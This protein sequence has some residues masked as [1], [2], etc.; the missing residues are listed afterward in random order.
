MC[1]LMAK[2][3]VML[4]PYFFFE[5]A[6]NF[7]IFKNKFFL[8]HIFLFLCYKNLANFQK[9]TSKIQIDQVIL[10]F[11]P[12]FYFKTQHL[13]FAPLNKLIIIKTFLLPGH[14]FKNYQI[15]NDRLF[16]SDQ[17]ELIFCLKKLDL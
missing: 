14:K 12:N 4:K 11:I 16:G 9:N 1:F 5:W 7:L 13:G 15:E 6:L 8:S 17:H 10:R 3:R 2:S